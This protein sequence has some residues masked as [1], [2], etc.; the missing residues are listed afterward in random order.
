V[1]HDTVR[2]PRGPTGCCGTC[3]ACSAAA[4][5]AG[6][7]VP[8]TANTHTRPNGDAGV[9]RSARAPHQQLS[10]PLLPCEMQGRLY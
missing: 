1:Q 2:G 7:L 4:A 3:G 10:Q 5:C 8:P 9:S 6:V